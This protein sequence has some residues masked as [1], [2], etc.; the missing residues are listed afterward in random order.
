MEEQFLVP[1]YMNKL[2]II[3]SCYRFK[4]IKFISYTKKFGEELRGEQKMTQ[5]FLKIKP[6]MLG[7]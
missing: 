7:I 5:S 2:Y 6:K 4:C 3:E 1:I